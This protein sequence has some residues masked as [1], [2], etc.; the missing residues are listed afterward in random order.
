[1]RSE[2]VLTWVPWVLWVLC[3]GMA[4]APTLSKPRG[5]AH[6]SA[7]SEGERHQ[8]HG[9]LDQAVSAYEK[10]ALS[11]ERRVDRDEA[12]Y[13]ASRVRARQ[14]QYAQAIALCD[15]IAEAKPESRRTLRA[16]LDAA[17]YR[18]ELNEVD[19]AE[20]DLRE[21]VVKHGDAGEAKSALRL[22]LDLRVRSAE[23]ETALAFV[24]ELSRE[25]TSGFV[26]ES[27]MYEEAALLIALDK[28]AEARALLERQ[29]ARFPYPHGGLWD[30][31]L[32]RLA[33]LA[34]QAGEP[35]AAIAYLERML[36]VHESAHLIGT[37]T[38][39]RFSQASLRIGR[40]Y[41]DQI[42]DLDAAVRAFRRTRDMFPKSLVADDALTEEA[43][44]WLSRGD[45]DRGCTLLK[46]VLAQHEVGAAR[47]RATKRVAADC[48]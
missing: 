14:G 33:D 17:R 40:I 38:R 7:L 8:H 29:V 47:R 27:L 6:L 41:R 23:P 16:K 48:Q 13:R 3:F 9:R 21:L 28:N 30:D 26:A 12:L 2:R 10:A 35:Q 42:A 1:M 5:Q 36:A 15:R 31:G 39:P 4:C 11:A 20:R 22:L 46:Q 24:Q 43:E 25:A 18:L 45:K 19:R 34:E 44:I 32:W 37:Y